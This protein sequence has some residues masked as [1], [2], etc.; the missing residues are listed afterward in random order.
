MRYVLSNLPVRLCNFPKRQVRKGEFRIG[1]VTPYRKQAQLLQQLVKDAGLTD[2]IRAGTVHRFQGLELKSLFS[3]RLS[4][5]ACHQ[6][7]F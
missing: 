2:V 3:I 5:Q 7:L 1:L 4:Q 6:V